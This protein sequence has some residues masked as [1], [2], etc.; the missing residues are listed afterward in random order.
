M[1]MRDIAPELHNLVSSRILDL[2]IT[3]QRIVQPLHPEP[4]VDVHHCS[5]IVDLS[6]T[7][8]IPGKLWQTGKVLS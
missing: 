4:E 3:S 7:L 6:I 1:M 2:P 5:S 8:N